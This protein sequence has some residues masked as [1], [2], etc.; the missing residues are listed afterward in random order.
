[1]PR[2]RNVLRVW[3]LYQ[4]SFE[5]L[6]KAE[7]PSSLP[8][9]VALTMNLRNLSAATAVPCQSR[10]PRHGEMWLHC[11]ARCCSS[12]WLGAF[13]QEGGFLLA[14]AVTDLTTEATLMFFQKWH[15]QQGS[16]RCCF[17]RGLARTACPRVSWINIFMLQ[18]LQLQPKNPYFCI[19]RR[20]LEGNS[21]SMLACSALMGNLQEP[22]RFPLF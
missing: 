2:L 6:R 20:L 5:K 7:V 3:G 4:L 17:L 1:M 13:R 10:A 8:L 15:D 11:W 9:A 18:D 21:S 22:K 16:E 12:D 14:P 19:H